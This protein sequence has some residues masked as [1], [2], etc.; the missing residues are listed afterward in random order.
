MSKPISIQ[1]YTVRKLAAKDFASTL[2]QIAGIGYAGVEFAGLHG[3]PA[4]DVAALVR[5][6]GL[7][8]SSAHVPMPTREN[9]EALAKD[10]K[11]IGYTHIISGS[12]P[13]KLKTLADVEACAQQYREASELAAAHGLTVG[14]HNHW[15]ELD[16][17]VDGQTP[18]DRIL[19]QAPAIFSELD[20]Y[21]CTTAGQSVPNLIRRHAARIP[22]LHIKDGDVTPTTPHKAVGRGKLD[23]ATIV[24]AA[25]PSVLKWLIVELDDCAT[26][27]LEAVAQSYEYL[28]T[29]GLGHGRK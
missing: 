17:L 4:A 19:A 26:D 8:P 1:L 9:I 10:A 22:L 2:R 7:K 3:M 6:L 18:Y 16:H 15:W 5:E 21:W 25:D 23:F 27:M 14:L 20:V 28:T 11:T 24:A 13:S 29:S 12:D